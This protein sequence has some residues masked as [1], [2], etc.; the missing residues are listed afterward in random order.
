MTTQELESRHFYGRRIARTLRMGKKN[1]LET[2]LPLLSFEL[3]GKEQLDLPQV[4]GQTYSKYVLEI[5]FGTGIFL[6][7]QAIKNL[8]TGFLGAEPFLTGVANLVSE[9]DTHDLKNIRAFSGDGYQLLQ[10][11]KTESLDQIFVLFPDPWPK[12]RHHK[13]RFICEKT[14]DEIARVLKKG[15]DLWVASDHEDYQGWILEHLEK[16][17]QITKIVVTKDKPSL[18]GP[19]T[20]FEEKALKADRTPIYYHYKTLSK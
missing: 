4:F 8:S 13:R 6:I 5:G 12:K 20:R 15:A 10:A 1:A 2:L 17:S 9:I 14:L 11:L 7:D 19:V 16:H 18:F 3:K